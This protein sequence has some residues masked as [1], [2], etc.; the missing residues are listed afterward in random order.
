MKLLDMAVSG[1]RGLV[2]LAA[3]C[4]L[5]T[6]GTRADAKTYQFT[7]L[8][9]GGSQPGQVQE[10]AG[11]AVDSS[12]ALYVSDVLNNW[13][14]TRS[15]GGT[16]TVLTSGGSDLG[17]VLTP[18]GI[19]VDGAGN[20]YVADSGNHR[21]QMRSA[22]G[23]WSVVATPG[24]GL[25]QVVNPVGVAVDSANNLYVCEYE[26]NRIQKRNAQG[27]WSVVAFGG[28]GVGQVLGPQGIAVDAADNLFVAEKSSS[29]VQKM[30]AD[31]TWT[32]LAYG[33]NGSGQVLTPLGVATDAAGNLYVTEQGNSRVQRLSTQGGWT[34]ELTGG[35]GPGNVLTP[36]GIAV[37]AVG[38]LYVADP[39]NQR[40]L[41]AQV[42]ANETLFATPQSVGALEEQAKDITLTATEGYGDVVTFS[43]ATKPVHGKLTGS[44]ATL[45]YTSDAGYSGADSFTF[46]AHDGL[47]VSAPA[48][49][50]ITVTTV[51]HAPVATSIN[52]PDTFGPQEITLLGADVDSNPLTYSVVTQPKHGTLGALVGNKVTYTPTTGYVG[53]DSFTYKVNDGKLDSEIATVSLTVVAPPRAPGDINGDGFVNIQDVLIALR[54]ALKV[55]TNPTAAQL[56]AGDV[57][58]D[59]RVDI[60]DVIL[61]LRKALHISA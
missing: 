24:D 20:L 57:N 26:G 22:Q 34:V 9:G 53:A 61:I 60:A 47:A 37:D 21:V 16:W 43:V 36:R 30:A 32:V 54:I 50:T 48:T 13:V 15:A 29:R 25:G 56:A 14:Q 38:S 49:V 51:N 46:V 33:G 59:K 6:A 27:V 1:R 45:T 12:G 52:M 55:D 4:C 2:V 17:Q 23:T 58:G 7:T 35:N 28:N 39:G 5:G 40:V 44:G 11:L 8:A 18:L 42:S 31:G 41:R 3:L 10:P 19:A